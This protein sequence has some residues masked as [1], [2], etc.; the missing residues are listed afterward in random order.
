MG[1]AKKVAFLGEC[2]LELQGTA[3]STLQQGFGGDTLNAAVYLARMGRFF[4]VSASFAT[5]LGDD[6]LSDGMAQRWTAEGVDSSLVRRLPGRLPGIYQI[7]V[8][9][10]GERSF[11]YWREQSAAK[12]Y[13]HGEESPLE[14]AAT[15]GSIDALYLSGISLAILPPSGRER[16]FALMRRLHERGVRVVFDNNY[17]PRLWSRR[18]DAQDCF[19]RAY[20]LCSIA[21]ITLDDEAA[22]HGLPSAEAAQRLARGLPCAEVV[23]KRGARATLVR[24]GDGQVVEVPTRP[25]PHVVDTTAAGDAFG[26]AYL[27]ARMGGEDPR[28]A[29]EW[30]NR[31]AARVIQHPGALI[32]R[33]AM[34]DLMAGIV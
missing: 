16:T 12:A 22:M 1:T 7:S 30:G 14:R 29:A 19:L 8:D 15:E 20:T 3:F 18:E 21:L 34:A 5:A 6:V 32:P 17:R 28:R 9:A 11:S 2:M 23:M 24:T 13:F 33:E 25:V 27:A 26:A 31:L 10:Y 4:K